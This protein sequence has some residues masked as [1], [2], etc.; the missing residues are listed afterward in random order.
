MNGSRRFALAA[1]CASVVAAV[2]SPGRAQGSGEADAARERV[3][4]VGVR[5]DAKPFSYRGHTDASEQVL[6]GYRGYMVEI[7]RRVL[8]EVVASGPFEGFV[9][10]GRVLRADR[11]FEALDTGEVDLLCGPDSITAA[12]LRT[13]S[14]SQPMFVSG[15]TYAYVDPTTDLFPRGPY[16]GNVVGVLRGT[17]AASVG[18]RRLADENV[19]LRFDEALEAYLALSPERESDVEDIVATAFATYE[20][21]LRE[22]EKDWRRRRR[23]AVH[24][25]V[26]PVF[27]ERADRFVEILDANGATGER[28]E[29]W[30][31][32]LLGEIAAAVASGSDDADATAARIV[33]IVDVFAG[34]EAE[35]ARTM[36]ERQRRRQRELDATVGDE[37]PEIAREIIA[38]FERYDVE[39]EG[40]EGDWRERRRREIDDAVAARAAANAEDPVADGE[41]DAARAGEAGRALE[42]ADLVSRIVNIFATYDDE[43]AVTE[44]TRRTR[45]DAEIDDVLGPEPPE[46]ELLDALGRT[47]D[48]VAVYGRERAR[49]ERT[50]RDA[51]Q[52]SI[53]TGIGERRGR[54]ARSIA[55]EECPDGFDGLPVRSYTSHDDGLP[56]LCEGEVL[57][58]VGDYDIIARKVEASGDCPVIIERFTRTKEV[59]AAFFRAAHRQASL[60]PDGDV[61]CPRCRRDVLLYAAFNHTLLRMMQPHID[62][63]AFEFEREFGAQ[64]K[65][66][67][68]EAFFDGFRVVSDF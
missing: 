2:P 47:L 5:E 36:A 31:A 65:S 37:P 67:D 64:A 38:I 60:D 32:R 52:R 39:R 22:S 4:V 40:D 45:R 19:L 55:T 48:V 9:V 14:V 66:A 54:L 24:A 8:R 6:E 27:R 56:A 46:A 12:R 26:D 18:L 7:C 17:T 33:A 11:R 58:Y 13:H 23:D 62:I 61:S 44:T 34:F 29:A 21:E 51:R 20:T 42:A 50:L 49:R 35:R 16:C 10:E 68:L 28:D 30:R 15:L 63:L 43:R 25:A 1:L 3:I 41:A 57:Y 53:D 59:Y